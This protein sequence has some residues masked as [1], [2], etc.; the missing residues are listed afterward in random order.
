MD[1][2][3]LLKFRDSVSPAERDRA[4]IHRMAWQVAEGLAAGPG[5]F[6]RIPRMQQ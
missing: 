2:V 5:V 6:A 4:R 1:Y 3:A